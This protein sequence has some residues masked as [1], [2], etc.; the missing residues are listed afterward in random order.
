MKC[1]PPTIPIFRSGCSTVSPYFVWME[2]ISKDVYDE[3]G[4]VAWSS[5]QE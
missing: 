1:V 4:G 3:N 2:G 5:S